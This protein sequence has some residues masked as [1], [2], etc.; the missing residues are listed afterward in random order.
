[1]LGRSEQT[2]SKAGTRVYPVQVE[3]VHA[4][5]QYPVHV[6]HSCV[7]YSVHTTR[8]TCVHVPSTCVAVICLYDI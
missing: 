8:Y 3:H 1:M 5:V 4:C 7:L 2:L 6:V